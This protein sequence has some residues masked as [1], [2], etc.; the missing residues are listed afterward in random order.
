[1]TRSFL[2]ACGCKPSKELLRIVSVKDFPRRMPVVQQS[3]S[4]D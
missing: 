1:M 4:A 2:Q 3:S